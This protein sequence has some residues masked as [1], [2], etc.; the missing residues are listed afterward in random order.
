VLT[1]EECARY[2]RHLVIPELGSEGQEKLAAAAVLVIGAGGLG[3]PCLYYLAAAGIGRL[4]VLDDDI[5]EV[6]NLQRQILHSSVDL[7]RPK[8]TSAAEK[9]RA[10]NPCIEVVEHRTRFGPANA[11]DLVGDYDVMV[12]AVDNLP[13]RF[14]LNDV[15]VQQRKT[16]VEAAI[17]RFVGLAMTIRGGETACYRCLFPELPAADCAP[18]PAQAGVFGPVAGVMGCIQ[19][20]E[21]IKV[22]T[23]I[24]RPL[25][26][27]LLQFDALE[28]SFDEVAVQRHPACPVCGER[29]KL[30]DLAASAA[31]LG[32]I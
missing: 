16:L 20:N 4:G 1:Q 9:L 22:V 26:G 11:A 8:A 12:T 31:D 2:A 30:A 24:G 29:P 17:L 21:V 7:G 5:V 27:R 3:S 15:C 25:Y 28:M 32:L 14:L 19:A 18:T 23:G 6:S 13:S 10:L